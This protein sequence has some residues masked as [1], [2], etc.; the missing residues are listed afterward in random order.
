MEKGFEMS[1]VH[2]F[3][4]CEDCPEMVDLEDDHVVLED[5]EGEFYLHIRC[6]VDGG[7]LC[8]DDAAGMGAAQAILNKN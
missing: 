2:R 1:R 8:D 6:F 3:V 5:D 7:F 4:Q